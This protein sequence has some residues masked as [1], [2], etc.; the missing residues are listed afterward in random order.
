MGF[1]AW[2]LVTQQLYISTILAALIAIRAK[3][4][5]ALVWRSGSQRSF[6][7]YSASICGWQALDLVSLQFDRGLIGHILG[8]VT[9]GLYTTG[10]R[11]TDLAIEVS[12]SALMHVASRRFPAFRTTVSEFGAATFG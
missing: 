5:P 4:R 9:L 3:W 10:R 11:L 1:G 12:T 2:A 7:P 8:S 6:L